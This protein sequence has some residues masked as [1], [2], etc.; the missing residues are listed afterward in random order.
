[1]TRGLIKLNLN[2][3]SNFVTGS[4]SAVELEHKKSIEEDLLSK[5]QS[6]NTA[7]RIY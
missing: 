2:P 5:V 4:S 7:V 1:M 6:L 3:L